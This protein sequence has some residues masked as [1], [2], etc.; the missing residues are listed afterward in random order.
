ML[1]A[2]HRR[3][4]LTA[5]VAAALTVI[6][7]G[8]VAQAADYEYAYDARNL[9]EE[10]QPQWKALTAGQPA[11]RVEDGLLKVD[12]QGGNRCLFVIGTFANG[13]RGDIS[14]WDLSSEEATVEFRARVHTSDPVYHVFRVGLTDGHKSWVVSFTSHSINRKAIDTTEMDTYRLALKDGKLQISSERH[15]LISK[16]HRPS[17]ETD[18]HCLLFGTQEISKAPAPQDATG[19]W[20][21]EFIRWTTRTANMEPLGSKR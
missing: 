19:G 10:A 7:T 2:L 20:E 1:N 8:T 17:S 14:A 18:S 3:G 13:V 12:V 15:G 11:I 16:G 5:F 9:P 21:M 4:L 6:N